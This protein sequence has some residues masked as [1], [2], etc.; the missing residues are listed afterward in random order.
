MCENTIFFVC[1]FMIQ[2][3][4]KWALAKQKESAFFPHKNIM[5]TK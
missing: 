4:M 1:V 2:N 3:A 5:F